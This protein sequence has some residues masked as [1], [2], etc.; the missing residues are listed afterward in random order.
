M[1]RQRE[2]RSS[3]PILGSKSASKSWQQVMPTGH[4]IGCH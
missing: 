3:A 4:H 2:S 1:L